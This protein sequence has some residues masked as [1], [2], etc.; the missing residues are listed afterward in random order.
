M[1]KSR[2]AGCWIME[3]ILSLLKILPTPFLAD[4]TPNIQ[5]SALKQ[6]LLPSG[7][8]LDYVMDATKLYLWSF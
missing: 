3:S 2:E 1:G 5:W 4:E 8:R 7:R 6:L